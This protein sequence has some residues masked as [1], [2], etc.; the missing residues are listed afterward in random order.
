MSH[1][2][3]CSVFEVAEQVMCLCVQ[4]LRGGVSHVIS[5]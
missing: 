2:S 1:S 5:A 3:V 4:C